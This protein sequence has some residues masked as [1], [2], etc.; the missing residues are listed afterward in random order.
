MRYY[1]DEVAIR[2]VQDG[3]VTEIELKDY[4]ESTP[5][6][7]KYETKIIQV[8]HHTMLLFTP[9]SIPKPQPIW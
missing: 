2:T 6:I 7:T 5:F 9:K 3:N 1:G 4:Q 8:E